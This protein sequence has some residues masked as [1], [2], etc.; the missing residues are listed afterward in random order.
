MIGSILKVRPCGHSCHYKYNLI[1]NT[2]QMS[3]IEREYYN[4]VNG[5]YLWCYNLDNLNNATDLFYA[6]GKLI[7]GIKLSLPKATSIR[8]LCESCGNIK[9]IW[10]DAP[11]ATN[12]SSCFLWACSSNKFIETFEINLPKVTIMSYFL[13]G[14]SMQLA[15]LATKNVKEANSIFA[16]NGSRIVKWE[17]NFENVTNLNSAQNPHEG[18]SSSPV[19]ELKYPIDINGECIYDSGLEQAVI[20]GIPQ[21]KYNIFPKLSTADNAFTNYQ[22]N[23]ISA[24]TILESLPIW[25]DDKANHKFTLGIHKDYQYDP[26]VNLALKKVDM[27]YITPIENLG[28]LLSEEVTSDKGWTLTIR[29]NGTTTENAYPPPSI[30]ETA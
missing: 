3:K 15:K 13:M 17:C 23:K 25:T 11:L 30:S 9:N 21:Y 2:S 27:D 16:S 12:A 14:S 19:T 1:V 28:A 10:L 29:W 7:K 6:K 4:D 8:R 20:D 26:E 5:D 24:I 22:L 18:A